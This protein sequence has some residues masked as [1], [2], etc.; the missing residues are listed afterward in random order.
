MAANLP[1]LRHLDLYACSFLREKSVGTLLAQ[2]SNLEYINLRGIQ[3]DTNF[4]E[5]QKKMYK[6]GLF[7]SQSQNYI[8]L[9]LLSFFSHIAFFF[10]FPPFPSFFL[11][12]II[13][14]K[15]KIYGKNSSDL[16]KER[17]L[18]IVFYAPETKRCRRGN[19]SPLQA[20]Q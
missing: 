7:F 5:A 10:L 6:A 20:L 2:C 4:V 12:F 1:E 15:I 19:G 8:F 17:G 18:E 13:L 14:M 3:L 9:F 11:L 16:L